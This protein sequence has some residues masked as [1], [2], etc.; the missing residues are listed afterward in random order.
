MQKILI[1]EDDAENNQML[2]DYLENHGYTCTQA[3]SGSEAKLL[4]SMEEYDLVLLDLMLP[5]ISGE[6]LVSIFS[7]KSP[8]IVLSAKSG[9]DSKVEVLS[10][11]AEDYICKPFDLPELLVRIQ[12]QFRRWD[13]KNRVGGK[14]LENTR[15]AD[16]EQRVYSYR[17]WTL[18]P[19]TQEMTAKGEQVE[20]TRHEFLIMELLIRNPKRVFTKQMIYEYAWGEEYLAEDK[21]INV[22]ISNIR[23]KLKKSGTDSYIQTVWGMGF[24]LS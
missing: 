3:F 1:V 12:V 13:R 7:E 6:E 15:Q 22:H 8:V 10:A 4:F 23:S 24:K 20:L 14:A 17:G 5:G 21:T 2:K 16:Y 18:N 19:D 9:L 11:G